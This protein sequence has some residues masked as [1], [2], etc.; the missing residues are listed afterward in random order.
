[1]NGTLFG[2]TIFAEVTTTLEMISSWIAWMVPKC[3][4]KDPYKKQTEFLLCLGVL[5]I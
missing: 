1:M 5:E 2:K 3:K 4:D